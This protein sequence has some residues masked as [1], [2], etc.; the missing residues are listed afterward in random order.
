MSYLEVYFLNLVVYGHYFCNLLIF[1]LES[2][3]PLLPPFFCIEFAKS[4]FELDTVRLAPVSNAKSASTPFT[5]PLKTIRRLSMLKGIV[6]IRLLCA[7]DLKYSRQKKMA[8]RY[9]SIEE[10]MFNQFRHE[11]TQ[12]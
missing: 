2:L 10:V 8:N 12:F 1:W 6:S 5:V 3:M 11:T 9:L 4:A 7:P